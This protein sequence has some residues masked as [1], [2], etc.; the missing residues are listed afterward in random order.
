MT[1]YRFPLYV[2]LS[3]YGLC[4]AST[5]FALAA[6]EASLPPREA[7]VEA[8]L[9]SMSTAERIGQ[10]F[11]ARAHSDGSGPSK[12][13]VLQLI[14]EQHIGGV[15]FYSGTP[16][17]QA[18]WTNEFQAASAKTRLLVAMDAE[19]G[20]RAYLGNRAP[21]F[22]HPLTQGA[23][24]DVALTRAIGR[25]VG[26]ELRRLGVHMSFAPVADLNTNPDNPVIG[27]RSFGEQPIRAA[28]L[29]K[30]YARGLKDSRILPVA[31]HFPGHG[32]TDVD[33]HFDLPVLRFGES[34]LDS[35]ELVPFRMLAQ[36][37]IAGIMTAHLAVPALDSRPNRAASLSAA[38][39]EGIL[40]DRWGYQ[41]LIVTDGL[42]MKGVTQHFSAAELAVESI[43]AG[44]DLLLVHANIPAGIAGIKAALQDG[45]LTQERIDASVR[46]LLSAKYDAGLAEPLSRLSPQGITSEINAPLAQDLSEQLYRKAITVVRR[47]GMPLPIVSVDTQRLAV[48][49]LGGPDDNAFQRSAQRYAPL[50]SLHIA[51]PLSSIEAI[52]WSEQLGTYDVVLVG[53]HDLTWS[54]GE[55]YGLL[56]SHLNM[57]RQ[58]AKSTHLVVV[59]FGSPYSLDLLT[60][61]DNLVVAYE[62]VELAQ[63]AAAEVLFGATPGFGS[64]PVSTRTGFRAGQHEPTATTYRLQYSTPGNAGFSESRLR[65]V[66]ALVKEAIT[67]RATPGGILLAAK[68]G[69]VGMLKAYGRHTYSSK[70]PE[71]TE[72]TVYDLASI[73]K[74]AAATLSVMRLHEQG[75]LSV[76][77]RL[78][79]HLPYLK[80]SNKG[81][82]VIQDVLAHQAQL[83]PW[84]P[85]YDR[86]IVKTRGGK[87]AYKPGIY[88]ST[89]KGSISVPVTERLYI[90]QRYRDTIYTLIGDSDL[91]TRTGYRYSDLGFYLM[92]EIVR[93]KT[94]LT[95]DDYVM[96]EFYRPLGLRTIG[97]NPLERLD[98][99]RVPPTEEDD[100]FRFGRIQGYVHDMGAAMLGGV[101][102]HAGLFSDVN[103]LA[104]IMQM[105]LNEGYYGGRRYFRPETVELFTTRHP[106]STRRALGFDMA[107]LSSR[108]STNM[109][110]LASAKTFGHLGF[111]GTCAWAD[112]QTGIVFV[113]LTNRTYPKMSPNKFGKEN[114]R[115]RMQGA[116]Y[117]AVVR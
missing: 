87:K 113:W 15:I 64:L 47:D 37:G 33:S 34:R 102:G 54:A 91:R 112:P 97:Y 40:R 109:S 89:A 83:K 1:F 14:R 32:D 7:W 55:N 108:G 26:R 2:L 43:I 45:T 72:Q 9:A 4:L 104:V 99:S 23:A 18:E 116:V 68:D 96:R 11:I 107:E 24:G 114:Y 78:D 25:E 61:F 94:G 5:A 31:K 30:A 80:G 65:K 105:L 88:A 27:R 75:E 6:T 48:L 111:T 84:I 98:K 82:L 90:D 19:A 39:G 93:V 67:T 50:Q 92:A 46:R 28:E 13:S 73:T 20:L 42:D 21:A 41:G 3:V 101:S 59:V 44:N 69:Q 36:D 62:D 81:Q 17:A 85:F 10:L 63:K 76:Y 110:P 74:I 58:V 56:S 22:P 29:A 100:Y 66:D 12:A 57:L 49:S 52:R 95:I 77:D 38:F 115:P 53:L 117:E 71:V 79:K 51:K 8:Q 35:L 60:D 86:T 103:D 106:K 16:E 70:S